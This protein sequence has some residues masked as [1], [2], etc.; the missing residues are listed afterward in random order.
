MLRSLRG[1]AWVLNALVSNTSKKDLKGSLQVLFEQMDY[2][3]LIIIVVIVGVNKTVFDELQNI[4]LNQANF[5]T[6]G[7]F[8]F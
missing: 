2:S 3:L 7:F 8:T 1:E 6:I 4:V 5:R